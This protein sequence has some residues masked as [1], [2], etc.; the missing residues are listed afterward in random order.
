MSIFL[1]VSHQKVGENFLHVLISSLAS[2]G[3]TEGIWR[4]GSVLEMCVQRTDAPRVRPGFCR[5][6]IKLTVRSC[7]CLCSGKVKQCELQHGL[8]VK[9]A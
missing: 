4:Q 3:N 8:P 1:E 7:S 2:R 6:L 5:L 9:L